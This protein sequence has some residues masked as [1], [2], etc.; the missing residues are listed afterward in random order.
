MSNST[1]RHAHG[2]SEIWERIPI[3]R[4]VRAERV[5][6]GATLRK[7]RKDKDLSLEQASE[8]IGIHS[9]HLQRVELGTANVT[10]ATL[11][12]VS[13]AYGIPLAKLFQ[14]PAK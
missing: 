10:I 3:K 14:K 12:A 11:V 7:L 13:V 2:R 4:A 5:R 1:S 6:L 8:Q 9:K